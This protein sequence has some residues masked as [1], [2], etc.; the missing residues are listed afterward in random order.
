MLSDSIKIKAT[1]SGSIKP[2]GCCSSS[3]ITF[4]KAKKEDIREITEMAKHFE[5]CTE[6]VPVDIEHSIRKYE[7]LFDRGIGHM[8]GVKVRDIV[9][10][11]L[12]CIKAE[13]LHFP[14]TM[15][16]ETFWF[17]LPEYRGIGAKLLDMFDDLAMEERCDGKALIHLS[18]SFP[19]ILETLYVQRGYKLVEKHYVKMIGG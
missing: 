8:F 10:G 18:D 2:F 19:E 6:H 7:E 16:I 1:L 3:P 9:V 15:M 17:V 14:R 11:G 4:Y 12:G 5:G 13:D